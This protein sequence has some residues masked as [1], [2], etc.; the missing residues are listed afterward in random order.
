MYGVD[1]SINPWVHAFLD[2]CLKHDT[3]RD[4]HKYNVNWAQLLYIGKTY[5]Y[6]DM[7]GEETPNRRIHPVIY[8][9]YMNLGPGNPGLPFVELMKSI[10]F[11]DS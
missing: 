7:L 8:S 6:R 10:V 9:G 1:A 11:D 4:T 2:E 3:Y 5:M